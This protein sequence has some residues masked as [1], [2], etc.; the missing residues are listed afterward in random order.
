[1][2]TH[3]RHQQKA[4]PMS[5]S[6]AKGHPRSFNLVLSQLQGGGFLDMLSEELRDLIRD[7]SDHEINTR[8]AAKGSITVKLKVK[9]ED[10]IFE[11]VP[12]AK[13]EKPKP[14][15]GRDIFWCDSE[16]NLTPENPRQGK[17]PLRD[18]AEGGSL[19]DA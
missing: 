5:E 12:E 17:L 10:G 15:M 4:F 7:L 9:L 8:K 6:S 11:I 3:P 16:H 13:V 18:V 1:M 19:R 2:T 14:V